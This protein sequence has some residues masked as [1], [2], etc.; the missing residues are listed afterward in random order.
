VELAPAFRGVRT[1]RGMKAPARSLQMA[2][3]HSKR[4]AP[5]HPFCRVLISSASTPMAS[6]PRR[7]LI[8]SQ[9]GLTPIIVEKE[10]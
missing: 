6:S 7:L 9:I 2:K 10:K 8:E 5:F 4:F 1:G 3:A